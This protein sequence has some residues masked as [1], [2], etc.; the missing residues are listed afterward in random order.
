MAEI[1]VNPKVLEWARNE[2]QMSQAEAAD[3]LGISPDDLKSYETG[4]LKPTLGVLREMS[5]RYRLPV[6]TLAMPEPFS[7]SKLPKDF[8][9]VEGREAQVSP[10]TAFAVR[11]ARRLHDEMQSLLNE[12]EDLVIRYSA[13]EFSPNSSPTALAQRERSRLGISIETQLTWRSDAQAFA[14]WRDKVESLGI[15]VFILDMPVDDCRGFSLLEGP[16]PVIVISKDELVDGAKVYTLLHEYC[17]ILRNEPGLSDLNRINGT[18][19]YCNEFAAQILMPDEALR[20]VLQL[21]DKPEPVDWEIADIKA[22]ARFLHVSQQALALRLEN[23]GYAKQG[24]FEYVKASQGKQD[25]KKRERAQRGSAPPHLIRLKE[26][27]ALYARN[28]MVAYDRGT[29]NDLEAYRM[30]DL[31]PKHFGS[32][33]KRIGPRIAAYA[34]T[35]NSS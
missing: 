28:V 6:A 21:P 17:H 2:A 24:F 29:L 32:L 18:E 35:Q 7:A 27:G 11:E 3:A 31:A 26:L 4:R 12:D 15:F 20:R 19:R 1:A 16:N 8:R 10:K 5:S 30:L 34:A 23:A 13:P 14:Q 25:K 22:G 33:K 9:T